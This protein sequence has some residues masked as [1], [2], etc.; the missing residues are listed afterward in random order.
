MIDQSSSRW[1]ISKEKGFYQS[2]L[3]I[4]VPVVLQ[5]LITTGV[6]LMDT[7]MLT[8]CGELELS[9]SSLANQFISLF[10][11]IC[12]GMGFGAAVLTAR[13]WGMKDI[14]SIRCI[15]TLMLRVCILLSLLFTALSW[16]VPGEIM[17]IYT[18]AE[19]IIHQGVLYLRISAFSFLLYGI[20]QCL[21]LVM[22]SVRQVRLP[23]IVSVIAFL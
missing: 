14:H 23:L 11:F 21:T 12:N 22:R 9:G 6:N 2:V 19:D 17:R 15:T 10:Q 5:S 13:Y 18:P 3:T 7:L 4:A 16:F 1:S 20:S 8:A